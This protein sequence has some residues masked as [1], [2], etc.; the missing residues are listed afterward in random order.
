M[1]SEAGVVFTGSGVSNVN[2]TSEKGG[3]VVAGSGDSTIS[4]SGNGGIRWQGDPT[5]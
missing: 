3:F 1:I 4:Y 2:F 5:G